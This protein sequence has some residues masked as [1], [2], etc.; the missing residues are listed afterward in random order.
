MKISIKS[1]L[2]SADKF[3]PIVKEYQRSIINFHYR[4]VGSR[5]DAEDLAQETFLKAYLK[6]KTLKDEKRLN[7]WLFSIARNTVIDFFRK[8]KN[9]EIAVDGHLIDELAETGTD[10]PKELID[11][12]EIAKELRKCLKQLAP[13]PQRLIQLLYYEGFS[14]QEMAGLLKIKRNT[15]KSR[16]RRARIVLLEMIQDNKLLREVVANYR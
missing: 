9:R 4:F 15:L 14:Y 13:E 1:K 8:N 2:T 11:K 5:F 16:L 12:D 7:G 10:S 6:F 3:E